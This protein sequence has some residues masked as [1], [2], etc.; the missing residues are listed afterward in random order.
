LNQPSVA[1]VILNWNGKHY[2]QQFLPSVLSTAYSNLRVVVADNG[3]TD[4]SVAFLQE[5]FPRVDLLV[6]SKN[7][8]FA[9][10]YNEALSQVQ[11]DYYVLLNSDVAVTP[12][13]LE[14]LVA[15]LESNATYAA[16][17]PKILAF[18]DKM[19]FEYAGACG[20]WLDVYGYPFARGRIFDVCEKDEGQYDAT[21]KVFWATGAAMLIRSSV[22]HQLHGFDEY[23]FAH[24]EEIDLCWRMQLSGYS[25]WCCPQAAVYHVGGGT[26]PRGASKKT[27]LN[28]RNNQIMLA[29]NLPWSEKW[30][31]IPYRLLLDQVSA[32]K[33]LLSGDGGYFISIIDAHFAFVYW[34]VFGNKKWK[35]QKRTRLK[36]LSG[37][38]K[39]NLVWEHFILKK[40]SFLQI[41]TKK[42]TSA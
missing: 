39:G 40:K 8:G 24:Q 27:Y 22:Y 11:A 36:T 34:L 2:L 25:V 14:P 16:C 21:Q 38:F 33:G 29:K 41:V 18:K 28:F 12:E 31:K 37:V 19:F 13:W 32:L 26:L 3:S 6:L 30:W 23:F 10:G 17:Q 42:K 15:L 5:S 1:I 20:G 9:K 7:F 4:D 35:S